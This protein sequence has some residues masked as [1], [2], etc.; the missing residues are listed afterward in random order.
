VS[1]TNLTINA[2]QAVA[3][4][5]GAGGLPGTATPAPGGHGGSGWFSGMD[6]A[7]GGFGLT[8]SS[9]AIGGGAGG[10]TH[11]AA[12]AVDVLNT[13]VAGNRADFDP[14][15][16]VQSPDVSGGF[17]SLG[18]NLIGSGIGSS[19][20]VNGVNGDQV[21]TNDNPIDPLLGPLADNGGPTQTM[22][23]LPGSPAL[24]AGDPN[25]APPTDQRGVERGAQIDI[26][27]YQ[28]TPPDGAATVFQNSATALE[29]R[30]PIA[31]PRW[32]GGDAWW[33]EVGWLSTAA[34]F[35]STTRF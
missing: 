19:S 34:N 35:T 10:G 14:R 16:M 20:F 5:S 8:G 25:G 22:A 9:G 1:I 26:G 23:L 33:N 18:H 3:G 4:A 12:G 30:L 28:A 11:A 27:A 13:I 24:A 29:P 6:G 15:L 2:N 32:P 21:G 31:A 7:S 17:S